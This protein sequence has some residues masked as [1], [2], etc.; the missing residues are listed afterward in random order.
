LTD[1]DAG[2]IEI[3]QPALR[4]LRREFNEWTLAKVGH[5][6]ATD[7]ALVSV[8]RA[9]PDSAA[10]NVREPSRQELLNGLPPVRE[11]YSLLRVIE[12]LSQ[13]RSDGA[14][15]PTEDR[16]PTADAILPAKIDPGFP[17]PV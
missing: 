7:R 12:C 17:S 14:A 8:K 4:R 1:R 10:S 9:R 11:R 6:M 3:A 16:F 13:F 15:R 5:D 2:R